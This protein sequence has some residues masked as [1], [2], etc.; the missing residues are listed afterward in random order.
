MQNHYS[1]HK[2]S[3]A[4]IA[5][6]FL[7]LF[8][9]IHS[10]SV[11]MA[12]S[13][14]MTTS[15]GPSCLNLKLTIRKEIREEFLKVILEDKKE[16]L[17]EPGCL[18]FVVGEDTTS[19]NTFYLHEEYKDTAGAAAHRATPHFAKWVEFSA[20]KPW[21][22]DGAPQVCK[23]IGTHT[24]TEPWPVPS[25]PAY[26]LQVNLYPK[27][28]VREDFLT[29]IA[30]N[31]K[32]TDATEDLCL[33]YVYGES[34]ETSNTFHFYEAYT[35]KEDGKEGFEAHTQAPHFAAWETFASTGEPF[36]K[37]PEVFFFK[38]L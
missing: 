11:P 22:E 26:C 3:L 6:I 31:K 30:A 2:W 35:G 37:A 10:F 34:M 29:V 5:W 4:L 17:K 19:A 14:T 15:T 9:R 28:E 38:T 16:S 32:G 8:V 12:T 23:F 7:E 36:T 20:T 21:T 1:N 25:T 24:Q 33:Q 27:A 13:T 18:Q